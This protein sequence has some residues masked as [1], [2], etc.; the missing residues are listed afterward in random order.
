MIATT[1]V[2]HSS[3]GTEDVSSPQSPVSLISVLH[4]SPSAP[5]SSVNLRGD[6]LS[7]SARVDSH[8]TSILAR[9]SQ[10]QWSAALVLNCCLLSYTCLLVTCSTWCG[11]L[12]VLSFDGSNIFRDGELTLRCNVASWIKRSFAA[13]GSR[14]V[15]V[16]MQRKTMQSGS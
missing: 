10:W 13:A 12:N 14:F 15:L 1:S 2:E 7:I 4:T 11:C 3:S 16:L 8:S 6:I 9:S 5:A